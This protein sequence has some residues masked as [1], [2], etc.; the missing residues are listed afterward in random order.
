LRGWRIRQTLHCTP[1]FGQNFIAGPLPLQ[2]IPEILVAEYEGQAREK[3]KMRTNRK[4]D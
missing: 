1:S 3:M 4:T 2:H